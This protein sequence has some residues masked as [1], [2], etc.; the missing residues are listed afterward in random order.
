MAIVAAISVEMIPLPG[1]GDEG[2][3]SIAAVVTALLAEGE[4]PVSTGPAITAADIKRHVGVLA[5]DA[6][7]GRMTGSSGGEAAARYCAAVLAGAGLVGAGDDGGYLQDIGWVGFRLSEMPTVT[8]TLSERLEIEG[9]DDLQPGQHDLVIGA[10]IDFSAGG[11]VSGTFDLVVVATS[12]DAAGQQARP[13]AAVYLHGSSRSRTEWLETMGGPDGRGWG[14]LLLP[15]RASRGEARLDPPDGLVQ[16]GV[17]GPSSFRL[18]GP[19]REAVRA[20][21]VTRISVEV[22]SGPSVPAYNVLA[23]LD[24]VGTDARPELA[25]EVVVVTGHYDH[26]GT[27]TATAEDGDTVFNGADDDASGVA[28]VLELAEAFAAG[29]PPART[30]VFMAVT[31]EEKGLLGTHYYLD[32][33][34]APLENTIYNFNFEMIGRPD[35]AVGGPGTFWLTGYELTNL[36]QAWSDAGLPFEID[37][38]PEQHFFVR[39]DN[40]AF[41]KRGVVGQTL[42]SFALH[43][44]YHRVSDEAD[45]LDYAHMETGLRAA[46][47]AAR[48][49][50]DGELDAEWGEGGNPMERDED[51]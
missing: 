22:S 42:S 31:G 26:I 37:P 43:D 17:G 35:E 1:S 21:K 4:V 19:W 16:V 36:G 14:L 29:P 39:S 12:E 47:Q 49:L 48:M 34:A 24:G 7:E 6:L 5:D 11:E 10:D 38:R 8:A 40:I 3:D 50:A 33:P 32:H 51:G 28:G 18:R 45:S 2:G 46:Y 20:G 41:V 44:D 25:D 23:R 27:R 15:G 9:G 13:D 30:M